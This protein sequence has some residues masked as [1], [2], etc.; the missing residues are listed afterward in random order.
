M[1]SL[2]VI[3]GMYLMASVFFTF[4]NAILFVVFQKCF[5]ERKS[6]FLIKRLKRSF[7]N[8]S[9][10]QILTFVT[11]SSS[12]LISSYIWVKRVVDYDYRV[13]C[14]IVIAIYL[15]TNL[16]AFFFL[17]GFLIFEIVLMTL[18]VSII[19]KSDFKE[20][21]GRI[22]LLGDGPFMIRF[23]L[24]NPGSRVMVWLGLSGKTVL[25]VAAIH[26]SEETV[27]QV[28]AG[29]YPE[30]PTSTD[31][32]LY[33]QQAAREDSF[34]ARRQIAVDSLQKYKPTQ[35]IGEAVKDM[36]DRSLNA[37]VKIVEIVVNSKG[38]E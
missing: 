6:Y 19:W 22:F 32:E 24:G 23:F 20:D 11:I 3:P 36:G 38:K 9:F 12:F 31:P 33:K 10:L 29:P 27:V 1:N 17:L 13:V 16:D 35:V 2:Y 21:F 8:A 34:L 30:G 7:S 5:P 28:M 37:T 18:Y 4:I 14:L 15:L 25:G 26:L